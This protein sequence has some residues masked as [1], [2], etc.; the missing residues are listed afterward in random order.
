MMIKKNPK[1]KSVRLHKHS[2]HL[3][4][5]NSRSCETFRLDPFALAYTL[6]ILSS[7]CMLILSIAGKLGYCLNAVE[8]MKVWHFSYSLTL[9]GTIGGMAEAGLVGLV[10][11]FAVGW[12]YNKFV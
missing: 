6:A 3:E 11:G 8:M 2:N 10:I 1:K 9:M 5:N 4:F 12:L 7:L